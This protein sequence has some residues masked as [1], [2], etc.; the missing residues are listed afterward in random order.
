MCHSGCYFLSTRLLEWM[1]EVEHC[2]ILAAI[3]CNFFI[4]WKSRKP[5]H[6]I[7]ELWHNSVSLGCWWTVLVKTLLWLCY[8]GTPPNVFG[9]RKGQSLVRADAQRISLFISIVL[10]FVLITFDMNG[11][12][13]VHWLKK[14]SYDPFKNISATRK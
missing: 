7:S 14:G 10:Y 8:V 9:T 5:H 11:C 3:F 6:I 12:S 13:I 4:T 2:R 1:R